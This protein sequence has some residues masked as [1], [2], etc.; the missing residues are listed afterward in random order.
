MCHKLDFQPQ[1]SLEEGEFLEVVYEI[2][3]VGLVVTSGLTWEEH[4]KYTVKRVNNVMW[5]LTRFKQAG[6]SQEK[7]LK[8]YVLKIRSILMFG[9]VCF[10]SSLNLDQR[11]RLELQQKRSLAIILGNEYKSY[12]QARILTNLPELN[13]LRED[14]C[15]KWAVKAQASRKHSHLFPFYPS[16]VDTRQ[17]KKFQEPH[18]KSAR[19]FNSPVPSMIR[20]LDKMSK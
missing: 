19:Y 5:Q 18:C 17:K 7:L 14:A 4:I 2:K 12:T 16:Q 13:Q 9:A 1:L 10:H 15:E 20:L 8:F 6:G 3:L 11:N